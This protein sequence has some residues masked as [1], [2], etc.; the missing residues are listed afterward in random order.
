MIPKTVIIGGIVYN[1]AEVLRLLDDDGIK[2]L[3]GNINYTNTK[4]NIE[5]EMSDQRKMN[6]LWHE[7][8]HGIFDH[9]GLEVDEK[10]VEVAANGICGFV[11]ENPEMF[12]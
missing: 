10:I 4:I 9:A 7:V 5:S 2:K 6:T 3:N 11:Q 1:V 8:I 12:K